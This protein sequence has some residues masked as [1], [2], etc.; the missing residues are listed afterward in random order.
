MYFMIA[1]LGYVVSPMMDPYTRAETCRNETLQHKK[2]CF[3][4]WLLSPHLYSVLCSQHSC[5]ELFSMKLCDT[6]HIISK[7]TGKFLCMLDLFLF[8]HILALHFVCLCC[9]C[10]IWGFKCN[11]YQD[12]NYSGC[13]AKYFGHVYCWNRSCVP[14]ILYLRSINFDREDNTYSWGII[15]IFWNVCYC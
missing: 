10:V 3:D 12:H 8:T 2:S 14:N 5:N 13:G 6:L 9:F 4:S 15:C 7:N 11:V 1:F